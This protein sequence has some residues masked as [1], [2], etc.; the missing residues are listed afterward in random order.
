MNDRSIILLGGP[1]SGKT[2]YVGRLW[3]ALDA[4]TYGLIAA[5]DLFSTL[6]STF[7]RDVSP[8]A[9]STQTTDGISRS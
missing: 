9:A 6:R 1:D 8:H 5:V 4:K 3:H 2:N 7:S